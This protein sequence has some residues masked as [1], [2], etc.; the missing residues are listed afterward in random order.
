MQCL[1]ILLVF[2][3]QQRI[4]LLKMTASTTACSEESDGIR[5]EVTTRVYDH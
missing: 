4:V 3:L 1:G 2:K 5:S